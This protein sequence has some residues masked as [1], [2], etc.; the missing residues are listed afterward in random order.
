[1]ISTFCCSENFTLTFVRPR[2][3]FSGI[4]AHFKLSGD[5]II[6]FDSINEGFQFY[7]GSKFY[8]NMIS[9][10]KNENPVGIDGTAID[11]EKFLY[12]FANLDNTGE[13]I[14]SFSFFGIFT[15]IIINLEGMH[16]FVNNVEFSNFNDFLDK[17]NDLYQ[18]FFAEKLVD[19][20]SF[21]ERG[22]KFNSESLKIW[23]KDFYDRIN[24]EIS[25]LYNEAYKYYVSVIKKFYE[26]VF[27]NYEVK[28]YSSNLDKNTGNID[29][30]SIPRDCLPEGFIIDPGNYFYFNYYKMSGDIHYLDL[31]R[32]SIFD[33][34]GLYSNGLHFE[35]FPFEDKYLF[36]AFINIPR[37]CCFNSCATSGYYY[38]DY[39][40]DFFEPRYRNDGRHII[41]Y[42]SLKD[43][44][45]SLQNNAKT[46]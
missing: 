45:E 19:P 20:S 39:K 30:A 24:N 14:F 29:L 22:L 12:S 2:F 10:L 7:S 37:I 31:L 9:F 15:K 41:S 27:N 18:V 36:S 4:S 46:R 35:S 11:R 42:F 1:M 16:F 5:F 17:I 6:S 8:T 28:T 43:F 44:Y 40:I 23:I 34:K 33:I 32:P 25:Y 21:Y 3:I 38:V 26:S 13:F